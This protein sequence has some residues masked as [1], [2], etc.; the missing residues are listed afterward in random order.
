MLLALAALAAPGCSCREETPAEQAAREAREAEEAQRRREEELAR[1]D[2]VLPLPTVQPGLL[3]APSLSPKPG[4]WNGVTQPIRSGPNNQEDFDGELEI[5]VTDPNGDPIQLDRTPYR[6][7]TKRPVVVARQSSKEIESWFYCPATGTPLRLRTVVRERGG[8]ELQEALT[9]IRALLD[10]QYHFVVLAKEP[11]RYGFVD[12]LFSVSPNLPTDA[13]TT[14]AS[15]GSTLAADKNYRVVALA[16]TD[17]TTT[18]PLPDNPLAWTTI[19][20][21]LWD[22]VDPESLRAEQREAILDWIAWGGQLLVSGPDSLDLLRGTFLEEA[23]PARGAGAREFTNDDLDGFGAVWSAT[24]GGA[25]PTVGEA[26][27][28]GVSLT[29]AD[30]AAWLPGLEGLAAERRFG[31]G[32]VVVTGFQLTERGLINWRDGAENFFNNALL[33]RPPRR[34]VKDPFDQNRVIANWTTEPRI[35]LDPLVNTK[36]RLFGRDLLEDPTRLRINLRR[37]GGDPLT[38]TQPAANSPLAGNVSDGSFQQLVPPEVRGGAGAWS[39]DGLVAK[40]GRGALRRSAGVS[41][42]GAGFVL[43]CLAAYLVLIAPVNW[44]FFHALGRVE[45]AWVAAPVLALA[46]AWVVVQQAQLDIGFVRSRT[47]LAV[48]ETQPGV[49]RGVLTRYNALYTS[50]S[51]TYELEFGDGMAFAAPFP[52]FADNERGDGFD[53]LFTAS[54]ERQEK[55]RLRDLAIASNSAEFV[56]SEEMLDL[57]EHPVPGSSLSGGIV[58]VNGER[59][60]PRVMNRTEWPLRHVAAVQRPDGLDGPAVLEGCWIGGL[61]PGEASSVAFARLIAPSG[62]EAPFAEERRQ[63]DLESRRDEEPLDL[64]PLLRLAFDAERFEPGE[65][66][67]VAVIDQVLPGLTITPAASQRRGAT[68]LVAHLRYGPLPQMGRDVNTPG[69]R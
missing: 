33:R 14:T 28:T 23:M 18:I 29:L 27:W 49:T 54:Y 25:G 69:E 5:V 7:V 39:D 38:W 32:R 1:Q 8:R 10:H 19:A 55:A 50:L 20:Y 37:E 52:R 66:R 26:P 59:G 60:T 53:R 40:A 24:R 68:V 2:W 21:V 3:S 17:T 56:L 48:L 42:P 63:A 65:R 51:T 35:V 44:F 45:L 11:E 12:S 57:A 62:D 64:D 41:I 22:E 4:H 6:M 43:G 58:L 31:R 61:D 15:K 16:A 13:D 67:V 47:E 30:G 46:G 9:P 34:F 36:V